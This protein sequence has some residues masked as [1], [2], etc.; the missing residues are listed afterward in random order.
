MS[1]S[2]HLELDI[3]C[4]VE[5]A[6]AHVVD[7]SWLGDDGQMDAVVGA[8]GW[9]RSDGETRF[10]IVEEVEESR[11]LTFR[12]ASFRE[13]PSRV[14]IGLESVPEGTRVVV[15]ESPLRA[16]ACATLALR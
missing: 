11:R 10:L 7:P 2:L 9:V 4:G 1:D 3:P 14:E 16:L 15:S 12:W 6:W 8:E 5:E 13:E